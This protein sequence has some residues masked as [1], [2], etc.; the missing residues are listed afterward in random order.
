MTTLR[1][2]LTILPPSQWIIVHRYGSG[3]DYQG[4]AN[5][6]FTEADTA[7]LDIPVMEVES[8]RDSNALSIR[9]FT[10]LSRGHA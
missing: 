5:D 6:A 3:I 1:K 4:Y 7:L 2:L 9:L 8:C 10:K